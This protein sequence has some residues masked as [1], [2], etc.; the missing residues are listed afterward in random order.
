MKRL[1]LY[2][3]FIYVALLVLGYIHTFT[4]YGLF[5]IDIASYLSVIDILFPFLPIINEVAV[6]SLV[7]VM[8]LTGTIL[9]KA[10]IY[11]S[12]RSYSPFRLL[13]YGVVLQI[14]LNDS[15]KNLVTVWDAWKIPAYNILIFISFL[16]IVYQV[17]FPVYLITVYLGYYPDPGSGTLLLLFVGWVFIVYEKCRR[18]VVIRNLKKR[19]IAIGSYMVFFAIAFTLFSARARYEEAAAGTTLT[20]GAIQMGDKTVIN[21]CPEDRYIGQTGSH[22]FIRKQDTGTNLIISRE[23]VM[24]VDLLATD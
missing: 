13:N 18:F 17:M 14:R 24:A 4:Y 20:I 2:I 19:A 15:Y 1:I 7:M 10:N 5:G 8:L 12:R 3:P 11:D 22:L 16:L 21:P 6:L 23:K 9:R